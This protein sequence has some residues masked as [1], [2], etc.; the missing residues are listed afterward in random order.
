MDGRG[1]GG[2]GRVSGS[3]ACAP[4]STPHPGQSQGS[5]QSLL[6]KRGD[7]VGDLLCQ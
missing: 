7:L 3:R 5:P 6:E 2:S 4:G 1:G